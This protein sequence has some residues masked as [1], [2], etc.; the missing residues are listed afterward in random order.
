MFN[1]FSC[2]LFDRRSIDD[3]SP[4][5]W[6]CTQPAI[7]VNTLESGFLAEAGKRRPGLAASRLPGHCANAT[8]I[9]SHIN[10]Q[11]ASKHKKQPGHTHRPGLVGLF[12]SRNPA[13]LWASLFLPPRVGPTLPPSRS[14]GGLSRRQN[15]QSEEKKN[16][17]NFQPDSLRPTLGRSGRRLPARKRSREAYR[18]GGLHGTEVDNKT[19]LK[20]RK[21]FSV[22]LFFYY[23]VV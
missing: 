2:A 13:P 18:I 14:C 15:S 5:A 8:N 22:L 23:F 9:P 17:A 21:L 4:Q 10:F 11:S 3:P 19:L 20:H 7:H 1:H 6:P 12:P 16:A